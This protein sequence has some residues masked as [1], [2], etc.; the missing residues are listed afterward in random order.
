MKKY[1]IVSNYAKDPDLKLAY[2][3]Q[4]Q[5]LRIEPKAKIGVYEMNN[6][7]HADIEGS[8]C[9]FVLGG[10]GTMLKVAKETSVNGIPL[11]G[12]N[13]GA[14]G[15]LAEVEVG[16]IKNAFEALLKG[17]YHIEDRMMLS[18][19]VIINGKM[20]QK[21]SALNDVVLSRRGDL[22]IIGYR[23]YVNGLYLNDFYADG[24]ILSTPTGSTGYNM[25]A[26]GSIVEPKAKLMV[27]TPVCPH[28]LSNRSIML[29][30]SDKVEVEILPPK[31]DKPVEVGVYFDG[32]NSRC[33]GVGDKVAITK[34]HKVTKLVK[35][36]DM[37]FLVTLHNKMNS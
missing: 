2:K 18:G 25:S 22:Q 14:L 26:G 33:L 28:T 23:V 24:I 9:I 20:V 37:S 30:A 36:S 7:S 17:Q 13:L 32:G 27:L 12:I 6:Y 19:E 15:F 1:T 21:A 5:M 8:E 10:D 3:L 16:N 29:S 34:S 35:L 31:G 4:K 11:L